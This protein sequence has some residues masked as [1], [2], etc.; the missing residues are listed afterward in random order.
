MPTA[1]LLMKKLKGE[2]IIR[3]AARHNLRQSAQE[4][5]RKPN[6]DAAKGHLNIVLAG[7]GTSEAVVAD[8]LA[9]MKAA[10]VE[11]LRKDAVRAV[12]LV[13][14][15][16]DSTPAKSRKLFERSLKWARDFFKVPVLTAAAH[17]DEAVHHAHIVLL[18]LVDGRMV[19]SDL[20]GYRPRRL[21]IETDFCQKVLAP[22]R[23]ES[24]NRT[25]PYEYGGRQEAAKELVEALQRN[26]ERMSEPAIKQL[27]RNA[28]GP[29]VDDL[30]KA[31]G[32]SNEPTAKQDKR[33]FAEIM[34][35]P[36]DEQGRPLRRR[37]KASRSVTL[38]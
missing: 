29:Y 27:L 35:Q 30:R 19:G 12:E 36:M 24:G 37:P 32:A 18:P 22:L 10:G 13:V 34:T 4:I 38:H 1:I 31:L 26:P 25:Q 15:V 14:S 6:I 3:V 20:V 16:V 21:E 8:S 33:S 9:R 17:F 11:K 23:M 7:A 5:A 2:E 28:I